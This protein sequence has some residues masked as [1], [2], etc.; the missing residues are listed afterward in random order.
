VTNNSYCVQKVQ[1]AH[2]TLKC[3][4][5]NTFS[6]Q[7][8]LISLRGSQIPSQVYTVFLSDI[9]LYCIFFNHPNAITN[10]LNRSI[11]QSV[12]YC[13]VIKTARSTKVLKLTSAVTETGRQLRVCGEKLATATTFLLERVWPWNKCR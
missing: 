7:K 6:E 4:D 5:K 9:V 13:S 3:Y 1:K 12:S 10:P 2:E 8:P 11:N